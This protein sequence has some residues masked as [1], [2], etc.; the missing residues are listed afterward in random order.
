MAAGTPATRSSRPGGLWFAFARNRLSWIG[1][2]LLAAIIVIAV[3]APLI[4]P[5]DPLEQNIVA[6]LEPPSSEF[7]LGT[8]SYG[9]DVLSRL[10]YGSRISLVVG[11]LAILIAM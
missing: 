1:L 5:H 10:I 4:A 8:D 2:V 7:R 6:R 3:F 9:R 11:F